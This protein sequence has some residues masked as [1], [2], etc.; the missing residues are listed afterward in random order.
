MGTRDQRGYSILEMI[1]SLAVLLLCVTA[2]AKLMVRNSQINKGQQLTVSA[3]SSARN[4]LSM[5]EQKL[6]SAGWDPRNLNLGDVAL[7]SNLGDDISEITIFADLNG[8]GNTNG[9]RKKQ[10][11]EAH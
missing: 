5:I 4:S 9:T 6:R 2:L 7:D 10:P 8:D 11:F 3:Q 1:V